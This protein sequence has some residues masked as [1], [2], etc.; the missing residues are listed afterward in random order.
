LAWVLQTIIA[1]KS[2]IIIELHFQLQVAPISLL[3][4][5]RNL[6][7]NEEHYPHVLSFVEFN[8]VVPCFLKLQFPFDHQSMQ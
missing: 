7:Q 6:D 4:T 2:R 5:T 1:W 3:T 8:F